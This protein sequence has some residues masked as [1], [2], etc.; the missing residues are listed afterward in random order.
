MCVWYRVMCVCNVRVCGVCL[1]I[2][3]IYIFELDLV[4]STSLFCN[5]HKESQKTKSIKNFS[6]VQK[7]V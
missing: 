6:F 3:I 4:I 7:V 2:Y 5:R 1:Y